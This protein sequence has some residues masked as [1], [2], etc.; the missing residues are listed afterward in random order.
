M[1][2]I[3]VTT[4][5]PLGD[6]APFLALGRRLRDRSCRVVVAINPAM[7]RLDEEEGL[8]AVP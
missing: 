5:G 1:A 8:E 2:R 3:V 7:L 6:F 4:V